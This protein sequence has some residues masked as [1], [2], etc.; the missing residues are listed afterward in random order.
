MAEQSHGIDQSPASRPAYGGSDAPLQQQNEN[1]EPE[2]V[3]EDPPSAIL[4][5]LLDLNHIRGG[6]VS[7]PESSLTLP[8]GE[9]IERSLWP[10]S[11]DLNSSSS[12]E[13]G[14]DFCGIGTET[15]SQVDLGALFD[16]WE[17]FSEL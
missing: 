4:E 16:G 5:G 12:V 7:R 10:G 8:T 15:F 11:Q 1:T 6:E 3:V 14:V 2:P 17:G 13:Y 9:V